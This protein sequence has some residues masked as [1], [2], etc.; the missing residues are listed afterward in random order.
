M[1]TGLN[2]ALTIDRVARHVLVLS[3][4]ADFA[5]EVEAT[6]RQEDYETTTV[7]TTRHV[8]SMVLNQ[9]DVDAILW[10]GQI[11]LGGEEEDLFRQIRQNLESFNIPLV[12][13]LDAEDEAQWH[14]AD[15]LATDEFILQ[16]TPPDELLWR[17]KGLWWRKEMRPPRPN[18]HPWPNLLQD[19]IRHVKTDLD[20]KFETGGPASLALM[21]VVGAREVMLVGP[22]A[23]DQFTVQLFD[24]L[25]TNLRRIDRVVRYGRVTLILYMPGRGADL[26]REALELL[27]AEFLAYTGLKV[28]VGLAS[29][30]P[31]SARFTTLLLSAD[32]ALT[33]A[34]I[35]EP[36]TPTPDLNQTNGTPAGAHKILIAD[37]DPH[38]VT[39][40][41]ASLR[42]LGYHPMEA[43]NGSDAI[44][45]V[46]R[47]QPDLM[48][49]DHHLPEFTG[50]ALLE[51]L[52]AR[53]GGRL[54]MPVMMLTNMS[55]QDDFIRGFELGVDDYVSKPFHPREL[56]ARIERV[57]AAQ[58]AFLRTTIT[59]SP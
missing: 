43:A 46:H 49:L 11:D 4:D 26:A 37:D 19:F 21:E 32:R 10:D 17:L 14:L 28:C 45:L 16:S 20:T 5:R 50:F 42:A 41:A 24:F 12:I 33:R 30:P 55:G 53:Y 9:N 31:D 22:E 6:L 51:H 58:P 7:R 47:E 48:I 13:R 59:H 23:G 52:R 29:H 27:R 8:A 15:K 34:Q 35:H 38:L 18:S 39:R 1:N 44:E 3:Q 2:N 56:M 40:L 57:L 36:G 25:A 54:P